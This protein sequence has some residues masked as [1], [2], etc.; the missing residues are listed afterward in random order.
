MSFFPHLR[1]SLKDVSV[2]NVFRSSRTLSVSYSSDQKFAHS[3]LV[4]QLRVARYGELRQ[5]DLL[6]R[7]VDELKR[8]L[9]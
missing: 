3:D 8:R 2:D 5:K 4:N 9:D 6:W 1:A 7:G